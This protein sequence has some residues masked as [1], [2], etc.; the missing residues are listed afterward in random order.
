E[1]Y[2]FW[3]AQLPETDLAPGSFGENLTIAGLLEADVHVGD[4]L[5]IGTAVFE[6]TQPRSP[7]F[8]LA[9]K[10]GRPDMID[11]FLAS[12]RV[13]FYLSVVTEGLVMAGLHFEYAM[14]VGEVR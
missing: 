2:D 10:F 3:R 13:G 7:C 14:E 9:L 4:Q 6:V 8:K 11:R 1:H 5:K 12:G